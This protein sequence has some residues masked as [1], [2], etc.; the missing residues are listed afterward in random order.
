MADNSGRGGNG[1]G[2]RGS[3]WRGRGGGGWRGRGSWRGNR[4][5]R[6]RGQWRGGRGSGGSNFFLSSTSLGNS[7]Q[8]SD[9]GSDTQPQGSAQHQRHITSVLP[10]IPC[11]DNGWK[12]Y[13]KEGYSEGSENASM[14]KSFEPY[15]KNL[16]RSVNRADIEERRSFSVDLKAFLADEEGKAKADLPGLVLNSPQQII[17]CLGLGMH[18][19]LKLLENKDRVVI[20]C[21]QYMQIYRY[22]ESIV[23]MYWLFLMCQSVSLLFIVTRKGRMETCDLGTVYIFIL[24]TSWRSGKCANST[25]NKTKT[26]GAYRP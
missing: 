18:L 11:P 2:G 24:F 17:N 9:T 4:G 15:L 22:W 16:G 5:W 14:L 21:L 23:V 3:N 25:F 20:I 8:G 6:G 10:L 1:R 26:K 19:V 7:L 13:V 12:L